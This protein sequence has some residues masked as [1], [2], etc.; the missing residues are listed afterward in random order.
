MTNKKTTTNNITDENSKTKIIRKNFDFVE[1]LKLY[2]LLRD[3]GINPFIL[4]SRDKHYSKAR[5]TYISANPEFIVNIK[6]KTKIDNSTYSNNSNPF[7]SLK[8]ISNEMNVNIENL[9][10]KERFIGGFLGY[11]AYD[12][13]HNYIGGNIE[14]PSV[15]GYYNSVFVYDHTYKRYYYLTHNN[16]PEEL[17]NAEAIIKRAKNYE[18]VEE[19]D[20]GS[21]LAGCDASKEEHYKMV[22]KAKEYIYEGDAFQV[23]ISKEFRVNS[24]YSP[25]KVYKNLREINPSPYM[26]LLEFENKSLVGASPETMASVENNILQINPIAGSTK[27]GKTDEE[28][29]KLAE[30]LL[31]DEKE[32]A[33]HM[34]LVD[35]ARNDVRKVCK[36]GSVELQSFFKV[37]KY[38]HIQHI[39]SEVIGELRNNYSPYDAIEAAFPAGTLTGAPK[40]RAMEI[41]D[42]IEK[43]RRKAYGGA[44]GYFSPN[45]CA[46]TAIT[47]RT[48]EMEK[49][50][51]IRLRVGGG[52]VA[53]S[54]PKNEYLETE[55]KIA[56]VMRAFDIVSEYR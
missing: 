23:V 25:F 2:G 43:S 27:V 12:C 49:D 37:L 34:M 5:F 1:P 46:D 3:E 17:K 20:G 11:F 18:I 26:F 31:K 44:V 9:D 41:I 28:S 6:N 29:K 8:E 35:L 15:F 14:E 50:G 42:E 16:S 36:S 38:S 40:Y 51:T 21:N 4:E 48:A 47:I 24:D 30:L 55:R 32:R 22:E 54:E 19:K 39:E 45:G 13:I 53:D 52:I 33:E 7:Q 56:A 10:S